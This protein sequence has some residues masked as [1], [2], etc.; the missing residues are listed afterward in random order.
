[1]Q[2]NYILYPDTVTDPL[3]GELWGLKNTGQVI[4]GVAGT[5]GIDI[6]VE[7]AWNITKGSSDIVVAIIDTGIDITHPDLVNNIWVNP[8][9]ISGDGI[10]N[11]G[12]G[13]VDDVNG[14]D[15]YNTD[16]TV[17][18]PLDG[19][20]HGT[21]VAGTIAGVANSIGVIGT[22]PN[23]KIMPLKFLGPN[24]HDKDCGKGRKIFVSDRYLY[25]VGCVCYYQRIKNKRNMAFTLER[26]PKRRVSVLLVIMNEFLE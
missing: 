5:P 2:P 17:F 16:N 13:Y 23:V 24:P 4:S 22:A 19:D 3:Y 8:G 18:D 20:E 11:D 10:D 15:F 14:W 6:N 21:H 7:N 25:I 26:K 1:M 12:N 9:E